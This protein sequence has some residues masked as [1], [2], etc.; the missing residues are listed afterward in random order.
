MS[1][2]DPSMV[3][4]IAGYF[5]VIKIAISMVAFLIFVSSLD[6]CFIDAVY[7]LRRLYRHAVI[8]RR[9]PRITAS[10]L[11]HGAP[12]RFI[13]ILIPAWREANV[14]GAMLNHLLCHYDYPRFALFVGVYPN[15]PATRTAAEAVR[16]THPLAAR[17]LHIIPV[18]HAGPTSK[19]D[20]LNALYRAAVKH[21][22]PPDIIVLH[23]AEDVVHP[24]EGWIFN[25]L[26]PRKAMVQLPVVP[27]SR[28]GL[29][30]VGG[31][32]ADEFA[33]A[34][35]KDL[36]VRE[37]LTGAA[38]SAGVGCAFAA[39]ALAKAARQRGGAPFNT[40]SVTEDYDLA[41]ALGLSGMRTVFVRMP[42]A[43]RQRAAPATHEYFPTRL[44][45]AVRQKARWLLGITLQGWVSF[46]WRGNR[47]QRYMLWRDRKALFTAQIAAAAY[48]LAFNLLLFMVLR[49]L[50]PAFPTLPG[51][52]TAGG[53]TEYLLIANVA[54]LANRL[55]QRALCVGRV[56][57]PRQAFLS[58]LR[59]LAANLINFIA[60]LRAL[61]LFLV[62][63]VRRRAVPWDK[64]EHA[65]PS[66]PAR[67]T[68]TPGL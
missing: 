10:D 44:G 17:R 63:L 57:G 40:S 3:D 32:Y 38:L 52:V 61:R 13:A 9:F 26:I 29:H 35:V 60:S 30:L 41:L 22:A 27:F 37:A 15:D 1:P 20:C 56:Y 8:Y 16:A 42:H 21:A 48:F 67:E 11:R 58:A 36:V 62:S 39:A 14:I 43:A 64:T 68:A 7:W 59:M 5:F 28:P 31:H 66:Q 51:L 49:R 23:D 12:A 19:A 53:I 54:L 34:H 25:H 46:G 6:D 4:L 24:W 55:L 18:P 65:F 47:W 33:E 50:W 45:P 2:L